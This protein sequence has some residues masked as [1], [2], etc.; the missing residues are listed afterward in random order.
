MMTE[1]AVRETRPEDLAGLL[2]LYP[3]AFPEEELRPVV[4]ALLQ[5]E[6]EVLSLAGFEGDAVVA[7]ILF[8]LCGTVEQDRSGALL[9]PLGVIPSHQRQGWGK[10]LVRDGLRRLENRGI[11]QALVLGD[12]AYYGR[13]GFRTERNVLAPYPIAD[14]WAD[15]W[16]SVTLASRKALP[17]G[18]LLLPEPWLEPALWGP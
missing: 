9:A 15:A 3:E 5:S 10:R 4:S 16:Q 1:Q 13:F 11:N 18:R 8:T 2:A 17:A 7:H 14:E 12:P 6:A